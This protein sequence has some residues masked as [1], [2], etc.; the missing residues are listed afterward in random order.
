MRLAAH[1][2]YANVD[3]MTREMTS[4]QIT[5]WQ[6]F[7]MREPFL[8]DRMEQMMAYFMSLF[9]NMNRGK[10][11]KTISPEKFMAFL[12]PHTEQSADSKVFENLE[13]Y[14]KENK[15]DG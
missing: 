3:A 10:G 1:L 12:S 13:K 6:A 11:K 8:V 7:Y 2:G 15:V 9:Y 4:A 5:E 14:E